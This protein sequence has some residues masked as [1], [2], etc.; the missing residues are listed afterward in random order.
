MVSTAPRCPPRAAAHPAGAPLLELRG[1]GH[2]YG[3]GTPWASTALRDIDFVVN[4]GDGLLIH[5][6][7][8][9]GKSTLAWIMAG[10]ARS[11]P[12]AAACST[13][14]PCRIRLAPLR[15]PSRPRGCS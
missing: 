6:L 11:P 3:S 14:C 8:G 15:S 5:G 9:S 10:P 12:P 7:N 13:A 1:V 4:E 2:E